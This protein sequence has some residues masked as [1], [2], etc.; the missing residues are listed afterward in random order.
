MSRGAAAASGAAGAGDG[1]DS[2]AA[3]A[4]TTT[5][6]TA[7]RHPRHPHHSPH[8]HLPTPEEVI[9]RVWG[10]AA[11]SQRV[12]ESLDYE[13]AQSRVLRDRCRAAAKARER[14]RRRVYGYTGHTLA[15][16][17]VTVATG[18]ATGAFAV[19]MSTA[20][21]RAGGWRVARMQALLDAASP[22]A[23]PRPPPPP[24]LS[25][26]SSPSPSPPLLSP[27][28]DP[29]AAP[30][31]LDPAL[32][33]VFSSDNDTSS[34]SLPDATTRRRRLQEAEEEEQEEEPRH[35][36]AANAAPANAANAA[37]AKISAARAA[38]PAFLW[39]ACFSCALVSF[40]VGL[41]QYWAP[42]AA[43]AGVTLVMAYLNGNHVP[44]LLRGRTLAA[45]FVGT[46][47]SVSAGLPMGP[48]GPMVHIGACVGSLIT[49]ARCRCLRTGAFLSCCWWPMLQGLRRR[50]G[51]AAATMPTRP[52]REARLRERLRVLDDL[53]G[54]ADHREAVSAGLAAGISA[55][56]G[57]PIGGVLF[58]MEE[59]CSFWSRKT[60]WRC[61][62]AAVAA[63]FT[64][65]QLDRSARGGMIGFSGIRTLGEREWALQLP[66]MVVNAGVAGLLGAAFNSCRMGLWRLRA[67]KTHH[68]LRIGEVLGL[69]LM[70]VSLGFALPLAMGRCLPKD[71][72]WEEDGYGIRFL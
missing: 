36:A 13:P 2:A 6:T 12:S 28:L 24:L 33:A 19:A 4:A 42:Q 14:E 9:A 49:Y 69:A 65:A 59:A 34:F 37:P 62:L 70:C 56:F 64:M 26:L 39:S 20:M 7:A 55:A 18:V 67:S 5:A 1:G 23:A 40:A 3:A 38:W 30:S 47:C 15:K 8:L 11:S 35:E 71:P 60:A 10:T 29:L 41:V 22:P 58:A 57:A 45:K 44:N 54:D 17:C 66:F 48:E 27:A 43:G 50:R 16:M 53:V 72:E 31:P 46:V 25:P 68:L 52:E 21:G 51:G 63:T 32:S 61:F